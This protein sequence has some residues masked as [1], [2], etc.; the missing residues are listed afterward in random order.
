PY[1]SLTIC[2]MS[3][4]DM[5]W[6]SSGR[7]RLRRADRRRAARARLGERE[8]R[9]PLRA[10]RGHVGLVLE[11][12]VEVVHLPLDAVRV[13][14]PELVLVGVA[15]IPAHLLAH[16]EPGRLDARELRPDLGSR[17]DLNA[18]VIHR[19]RARTSALGQSEVHR[20]PRRQELHVPGLLLDG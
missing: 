9:R 4:S 5:A 13:L 20:T 2:L 8:P 11:V 6:S 1:L 18:Q 19:A 15:A 3:W 16:R 12:V 10:N 14:H 17:L 7:R